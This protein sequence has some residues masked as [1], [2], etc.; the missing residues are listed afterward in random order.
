M[1]SHT[2]TLDYDGENFWTGPRAHKPQAVHFNRAVKSIH[3]LTHRT[4]L[5]VTT[6][7]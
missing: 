2:H 4:L 5:G 1:H 3:A 7:F 6:P